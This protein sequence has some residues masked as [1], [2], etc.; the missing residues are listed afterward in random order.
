MVKRYFHTG[1]NNDS[2]IQHEWWTVSD[3]LTLTLG[4]R[5]VVYHWSGKAWWKWRTIPEMCRGV[6]HGKWV[7]LGHPRDQLFLGG[8]EHL[9][10]PRVSEQALAAQ[11]RPTAPARS[12]RGHRGSPSPGHRAPLCLAGLKWGPG[13]GFGEAAGEAAE[14]PC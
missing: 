10:L 1:N 7:S 2:Q 3:I 14:G 13:Q 4:A 12:S 6:P 11:D 5:V 8:W 9:G